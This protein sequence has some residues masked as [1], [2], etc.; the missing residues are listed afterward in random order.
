MILK[1]KHDSEIGIGNILSFKK[2]VI[3]T[4]RML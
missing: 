4:I 3:D 2:T 1:T